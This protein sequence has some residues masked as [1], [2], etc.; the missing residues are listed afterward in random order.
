MLLFEIFS[1]PIDDLL[2]SLGNI[3]YLLF[4]NQTHIKIVLL[5]FYLCL[6]WGINDNDERLNNGPAIIQKAIVVSILSLGFYITAPLL[7]YYVTYSIEFDRLIHTTT[8]ILL[9]IGLYKI[10]RND[11]LV[12]D[13]QSDPALKRPNGKA[14]S[15]HLLGAI[16]AFI[17]CCCCSYFF[18]II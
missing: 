2:S 17:M 11:P 13:L 18:H 4:I 8:S 10:I 7:H 12:D 6:L 9:L 5:V 3:G 15:I 1:T 16:A 14:M